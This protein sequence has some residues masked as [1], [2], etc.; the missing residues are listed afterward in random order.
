VTEL[1]QKTFNLGYFLGGAYSK[2]KKSGWLKGFIVFF[3][4]FLIS[5]LVA[6]EIFFKSV[7][8]GDYALVRLNS[9]PV[10]G[11]YIFN[12]WNR[13]AYGESNPAPFAYLF[14]YLFNQ[15]ASYVGRTEARAT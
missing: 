11:E 4:A 14:L 7:V 15:L 9:G 5:F 1:K 8:F 3:C 13:A 10:I 12:D 2:C 6:R